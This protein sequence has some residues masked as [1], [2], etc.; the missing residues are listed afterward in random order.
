MKSVLDLPGFLRQRQPGDEVDVIVKRDVNDET[1]KV[2]L[3]GLP[4]KR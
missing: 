4:Q 1:L 2:K 3:A